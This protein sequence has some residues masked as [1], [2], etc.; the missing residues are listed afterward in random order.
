ME[1]FTALLGICA[2]NSPVTGEFPTQ[3]PVTRGFDVLFDLR[4][5]NSWVNNREAGDLRSHRAHYDVI[6]YVCAMWGKCSNIIDTDGIQ[7]LKHNFN[8]IWNTLDSRQH[9]PGIPPAILINSSLLDKMTA[10]W[11]TMISDAF[12]FQWI[13]KFCTWI[14]NSGSGPRTTVALKGHHYLSFSL[15]YI[16][17][18]LCEKNIMWLCIHNY[19]ACIHKYL[20]CIHNYLACIHN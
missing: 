6:V 2:G 1:T 18:D 20:A 11:Q 13:K 12:Y 7:T 14:K 8:R 10:I 3:R 19:L 17:F 16:N 15:H 4:L 5:K 9:R